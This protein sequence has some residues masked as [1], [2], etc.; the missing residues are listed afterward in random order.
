MTKIE[1]DV[2]KFCN[3]DGGVV[4]ATSDCP[5]SCYDTASIDGMR[6]DKSRGPVPTTRAYIDIG[7]GCN[8]QCGF[9]YYIHDNL[10]GFRAKEELFREIDG[11]LK[12]GCNCIDITGGEPTMHPQIIDIVSYVRSRGAQCCIITNGTAGE[13]VTTK[14]LDA[15]ISEYLVSIHAATNGLHDEL[16][17]LQGARKLQFRFLDQI[18]SAGVV[19]LCL[20]FNCVINKKNQTQLSEIA[21]FAAKYNPRIF[22][23][24]NLNPHHKWQADPKRTREWI[25]DLREAEAPL[26]QAIGFLEKNNISVNVRYWPMCRINAELR[27][28]VCND[29][30]VVFD[31]YEWDYSINLRTLDAFKQWAI[32]LSGKNEHKGQPCLSCHLRAV[33]GGINAAFYK[34]QPNAVESVILPDSDFQKLLSVDYF[35]FFYRQYNPSIIDP[36]PKSHVDGT[37]LNTVVVGVGDLT[38]NVT[39][40]GLPVNFGPNHPDWSVPSKRNKFLTLTGNFCTHEKKIAN[41]APSLQP[42]EHPTV[43]ESPAK[44]NR[45]FQSLN[46]DGNLCIMTIVSGLYQWYAP[47]FMY[48]AKKAYPKADIRVYIHGDCILPDFWKAQVLLRDEINKYPC[49]GF[50]TA[51]VR[52]VYE[53]VDFL[54][55]NIDYWLITDIDIL[56]QFETPNIINQHCR[57]MVMHNLK[58]YDNY[59][60][61][62]TVQG[63]GRM[64]GVHFITRDWWDISRPA[65]INCAKT[66]AEKG[67]GYWEY[68]EVMLS[69]IVTQSGLPAHEEQHLWAHHGLHLGAWRRWLSKPGI[70]KNSELTE[71]HWNQINELLDDNEFG[72][73]L[74]LCCNHLPEPMLANIFNYFKAKRNG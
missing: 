70:S 47:L 45:Y 73:I 27:R 41:S 16:V 23:F 64:P 5:A 21:Q 34:V 24:I 29:L 39:K 71:T 22:N 37:P 35:P 40:Y 72:E 38:I 8:Q 14:L 10:S 15:G 36:Y 69:A 2:S 65:R 68:D 61:Q 30:H 7:R 59:I 55:N 1:T 43:F 12:R 4:A 19:S 51:A 56:I 13:S 31:P 60:S 26:N 11:A 63:R 57:S 44:R 25:A 49:N 3:T 9:C 53:D 62:Y 32:D 28:T 17:G 66:L 52:F 50:T 74:T 48:C 20:R 42:G 18:K 33:C 67:A 6:T 54:I 46:F 58:C